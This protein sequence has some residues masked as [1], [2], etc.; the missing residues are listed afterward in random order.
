ML[1]SAVADS[2]AVD[3]IG[4]ASAGTDRV[5]VQD[6]SAEEDIHIVAVAGNRPVVLPVRMPAAP[7]AVVLPR[8][9]AYPLHKLPDQLALQQ[10]R[11]LP[12][13]EQEQLKNFLRA[14]VQEYR[15]QYQNR[16]ESRCRELIARPLRVYLAL[17]PHQRCVTFE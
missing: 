13:F 17:L 8:E 16:S 1:A 15:T 6:A 2:P 9:S 7:D 4:V 3:S 12:L 11:V 10:R 14:S 5:A